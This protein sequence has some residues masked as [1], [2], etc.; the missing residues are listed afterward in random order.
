[1]LRLLLAAVCVGLSLN[2][3]AQSEPFRVVATTTQAADLLT[4]LTD[5]AEEVL[6]T[7]LMGPGVDPHLYQPTESDIAAMNQAE[8]VVYNGLNL[9]GQFG[10]VFRALS[11]RGVTIFS[12]GEVVK[13]AGFIVEAEDEAGVDDPHFWFDPLNWALA[14]EAL[15]EALAARNPAN[16]EVYRENA[17][18]YVA[19]LELL[20]EWALAAMRSVP[21]ERR[22][23]LTSHDAFFYFGTAFGWRV[24]AVQGISTEAEAGVGDIQAVVQQVIAEAIPVIFVESSVPPNTIRA[25]VEAVTA[26]GGVVQVGMRDLYSDAMGDPDS[27]AGTYVGMIAENVYTILQSFACAG[28]EVTIPEWPEDL[29]PA[30]PAELLE[31]ACPTR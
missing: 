27:F 17:A 21:E 6:V 25:V 5:G 13:A 23:L 12:L 14:T 15:A 24:S 7:G 11:E 3:F 18:A 8:M 9:E 1:M 16:A 4:I 22:H 28:V 10:A 31:A 2:V 26:A 20:N 29:L 30:P 19:Q